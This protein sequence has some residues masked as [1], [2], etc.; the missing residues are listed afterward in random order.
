MKFILFLGRACFSAIFIVASLGHFVDETIH[1]AASHGVP[2]PEILVPLSGVMALLGGLSIFFGYKARFGA[3]L[4]VLFLIPVTYKM[5]NFWDAQDPMIAV[6]EQIM[7]FKNI[8]MLG[9]AIILT[10]F[11]SGPMSIDYKNQAA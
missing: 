3:W 2:N 9:G 5:H 10:Y 6:I 7:F 1:Y 8:S 4:I 11:G